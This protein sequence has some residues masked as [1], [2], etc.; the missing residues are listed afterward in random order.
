MK[1]KVVLITGGT[2]GIGFALCTYF[3]AHGSRIAFTSREQANIDA[4]VKKLSDLGIESFGIQA[5]AASEVDQRKAVAQ[6]MNTYGRID[7]LINNAGVSMRALF[8][9]LDLEV[10]RQVMDTNFMGTVYMTKAALPYII[11]SKGS[12][13]GISS[14]AGIVGLPGRTAYSA[15][16]FAMKG[17]LESLEC[18][19]LK[20]GVHV[21]MAY[22]GFTA[23][24]IR[25]NALTK[26]GTPQGE[27]PRTEEKMMMPEEVAALIYEAVL[28]R[29]R[30]VVMTSEGK[31]THWLNK[32]IPAFVQRKVYQKMASEPGSGM[33]PL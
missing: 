14:V 16:K 13:V 7:V 5:N 1:D 28:K 19:L 6:T 21:L 17:F 27:S 12:I 18:E 10:F 33:E 8:N 4:T 20:K 2:S 26:D 22:P 29:K 31:L 23:S 24:Q 15:S 30:Q 3:G 32:F 25:E 9:E 11:R